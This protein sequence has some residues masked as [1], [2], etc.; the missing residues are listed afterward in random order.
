MNIMEVRSPLLSHSLVA[1]QER[2]A[3]LRAIGVIHAAVFGSVAR[4]DDG[5]SSDVDVLIE[6]SANAPVGTPEMLRIEDELA[7]ALGRSVDVVSRG[8]LRSPRHDHILQ[9]MVSAF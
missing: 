4:G 8:G 3:W 9:E 5:P 2:E 7:V 1:L 6:L